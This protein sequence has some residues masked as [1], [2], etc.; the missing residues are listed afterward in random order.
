M[1]YYSFYRPAEGRRLSRPNKVQS[2]PGEQVKSQMSKPAINR[3][4]SGLFKQEAQLSLR[5]MHYSLYSSCCSD[6]VR[7]HP[8]SMI[9][10]LIWKGICDF[11]SVINRNLGP[12]LQRLA[13]IH[14]LHTDRQT[15]DNPCHGCSAWKTYAPWI[16][17]RLWCFINHLLT[18][19]KTPNPIKPT[20]LD[21]HLRIPW[22]YCATLSHNTFI[23]YRHYPL[24]FVVL[25]LQTLS[26]ASL[27]P[28][29]SSRP[30]APPSGS[31]KCLRFGHWLTLCT[32]N[33]SLTHLLTYLQTNTRQP[34][35]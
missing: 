7:G 26:V 4:K 31:A 9:F 6:D 12:I 33:I 11:L 20:R 14:S 29:A 8:R 2:D 17:R 1:S 15:H 32:L 13:T 34:V 5:K 23:T 24:A 25:P 30:T 10:H 22:P 21:L 16:F 3:F 18:Y 28:T 27:K 35:P 19:S